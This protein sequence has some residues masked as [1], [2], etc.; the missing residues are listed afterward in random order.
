MKTTMTLT[1]IYPWLTMK[2]EFSTIVSRHKPC[3]ARVLA[4]FLTILTMIFVYG[5]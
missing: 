1:M 3:V 4:D 5:G 2:S